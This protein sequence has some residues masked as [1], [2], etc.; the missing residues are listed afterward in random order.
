MRP[1]PMTMTRARLSVTTVSLRPDGLAP[2]VNQSCVPPVP[3]ALYPPRPRLH[4]SRRTRGVPGY[5][6]GKLIGR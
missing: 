6:R 4:T 5:P 3:P 1:A 2:T